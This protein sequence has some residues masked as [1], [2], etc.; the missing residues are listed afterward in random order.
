MARC[1]LQSTNARAQPDLV[2]DTSPSRHPHPQASVSDRPIPLLSTRELTHKYRTM[3]SARQGLIG[4]QKAHLLPTPPAQ[5]PTRDQPSK[6][7]PSPSCFPAS[8]RALALRRSVS[9]TD[10]APM[11]AVRMRR[12]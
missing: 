10:T 12:S 8:I 5:P 11:S 7:I 2:I 1:Q 4:W 3:K 9:M 6:M